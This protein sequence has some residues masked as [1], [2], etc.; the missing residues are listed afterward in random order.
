[1]PGLNEGRGVLRFYDQ[2]FGLISEGSDLGVDRAVR[3]K[4]EILIQI[5]HER[6]EI[7][8]AVMYV[9]EEEMSFREIGL[10]TK[11]LADTF[12]GLLQAVQLEQRPA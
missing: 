3:F 2:P 9:G 1:M 10:P 11:R 4:F 6:R 12:L 5:L 7:M 8:L